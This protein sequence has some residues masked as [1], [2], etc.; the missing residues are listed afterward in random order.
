MVNRKGFVAMHLV[1]A[2]VVIGVLLIIFIAV[3]NAMRQTRNSSRTQDIHL[4]GLLIK[5]QQLASQTGF[6]PPSC[7]NTQAN[8]FSRLAKLSFYDNTS[9]SDTVI[10]YY[11]NEQQFSK[12]SP[13]LDVNDSE[14]T[15]KVYIHTYATCD[16]DRPSGHNASRGS[17]IIQYAVEGFTSPRL[18]CKII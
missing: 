13:Q 18:V 3:P 16:Q 2:G 10:T 9:N 12:Y 17:V 15:G 5:D 7:N 4:L 1:V 6:L 14:V 11:R 8:C